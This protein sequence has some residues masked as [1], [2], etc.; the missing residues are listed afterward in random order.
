MLKKIEKIGNMTLVLALVLP[1]LFFPNM[2]VKGQ[3]LADVRRQ[4][5][6]KEAELEESKEKEKLT[7]EEIDKI[8]NSI[9]ENTNTINRLSDEM[10]TLQSEITQ[11]EKDIED[12]DKEIK[13]II[14]FLQVSS[15]ESAY[16][17]YAFG[18]KDFTDFIYRMAISEQ[19]SSYNEELV[20][21][22]NTLIESNKKKKKEKEEKQ[23]ELK[24][25][26]IELAN[27]KN[28][29]GEELTTTS[30][31]SISLEKDIITV[32]ADIKKLEDQKCGED[33]E[34]EDCYN[35]TQTLPVGTAF[36]RPIISGRVT[37]EFG[38]RCYYIYEYNKETGKNEKVYRCDFH[39]AIDMAQSGSAVPVYAAAPG[40]VVGHTD[41]GECGGNMVY[42]IHNINGKKY[43][44]MYAHLRTIMVRDD[45]V[46]TMDTQIGTM[47]GNPSIEWWDGCSTGQHVHFALANGHY[48]KDYYYWS[49]FE[50][51]MFNP[52]I[53][54]N[55]PA[56]GG[57]F[58]NRFRK[59]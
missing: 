7:Q 9:T 37:S 22:Y 20:D 53:M 51:N 11:A 59:Y 50:A 1:G 10:I 45:Q 36:Y 12:K 42:I 58:N 24:K 54:L 2:Q 41:R 14:N 52:R 18:A 27:Q 56:L 39:G 3:T 48:K 44:S 25:T 6:E 40:I 46:V 34:I 49:Q 43:T 15:G 31:A 16:L 33:E 13:E 26:Q 47:G 28:K 57:S 29:L 4:L 55:A 23:E 35:R 8:T 30:A 5:A 19:L 32:K 17:E 21:E 38:S